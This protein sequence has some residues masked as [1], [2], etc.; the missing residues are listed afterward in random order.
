[1][2]IHDRLF[3]CPTDLSITPLRPRRIVIIGSCL[4]SGWPA[5]IKTAETGCP[6]D[7]ILF[8][9][10]SQLAE[11]PPQPV[12]DY[13]F[14]VVQL[15]IRSVLPDQAFFRLGYSDISAYEKLLEDAKQRMSQF[16]AAAMRW[17]TEHGMLSFVCNFMV[18]QQNPMGRLLP[19]YDLRNFVY[20]T[21]QLNEAL[22]EELKKYNNAYLLDIDQIVSTFGRRYFQDDAVC[23]SNHGAALSNADFANDQE[24][25]EAVPKMT[26]L[27]SIR[28]HEYLLIIWNELV[29]MY[30]TLRQVDMVKLV[31]VD[32]D[33]T[34]WRGVAAEKATDTPEMAGWPLGLAEALGYLKRRGVLLAIASKNDEGLLRKLWDPIMGVHLSLEDFAALKVNWLPKA[35]N[36][37]ELLREMNLLPGNVLFVDDNPV[38]RASVQAA[39]PG[40]RVMGSNPYLWRR[41]LLWSAETQVAGI[42]AESGAR[43]DMM[44]AQVERE[45]AR[46]QMSR[47][48][49]LASLSLR[50]AVQEIDAKHERF[51]RALELINKTNQFNT[52]GKR[53]TEQELVATLAKGTKLLV[54]GVKDNFTAY[55]VVGVVIVKGT[56]IEQFVMSCRVAGMDVEIGAVSQV[57]KHMKG[58]RCSAVLVDTELNLLCRD[59]YPRC[60]FEKQGEDWERSLKPA[61][62]M[63]EHIQLV[64]SL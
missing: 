15:P 19:R 45:G 54:F 28:N 18:P 41:I 63:P 17:N 49:F 22:T 59:L 4:A 5:A 55:G 43:T 6:A 13:D 40:M 47:G 26:E 21:E 60:G 51:P 57:L 3:R 1:M 58:E 16:L 37:K 39:F 42:T 12:E 50:L 8:N 64:K 36:I 29:A 24:R 35:E 53:W 7:Y 32:I 9:N 56:R 33:D 11:R 10:F 30:R 25:L 38:E 62:E 31:I 46:Q 61:L 48:D 27:Y 23:Q 20:F 14:Q 2:K 34:L 52:T 44:R